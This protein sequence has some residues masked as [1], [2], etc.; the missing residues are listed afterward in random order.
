SP[1][2]RD[3][4]LTISLGRVSWDLERSRVRDMVLTSSV[5]HM[6]GKVRNSYFLYLRIAGLES[7]SNVLMQVK[8]RFVFSSH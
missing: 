7:L 8:K 3:N 6:C 4:A 5:S 1:S 2:E